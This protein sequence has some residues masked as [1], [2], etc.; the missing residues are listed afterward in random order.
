MAPSWASVPFP[1][2]ASVSSFSSSEGEAVYE[3]A[4]SW[5]GPQEEV[6]VF[7]GELELGH[8]FEDKNHV[9]GH[10]DANRTSVGIAY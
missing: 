4:V 2:S 7:K 6:D 9:Y 5:R 10:F 1:Y 3:D 8:G